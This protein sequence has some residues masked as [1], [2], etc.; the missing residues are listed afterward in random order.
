[1]AVVL[2]SSRRFRPFTRRRITTDNPYLLL[3]GGARVRGSNICP[4]PLPGIGDWH[5]LWEDWPWTSWIKFQVDLL[6]SVGGN[7]VRLMGTYKGVYDATINIA[8]VLDR[9][10]QLA[11]YTA[12][13]GMYLYPCVGGDFAGAY[14]YTPS[15]AF[16]ADEAAAVAERLREYDHIIGI[17]IVQERS[18]SWAAT[19]GEAA[20]SAVKAET[21]VPLTYSHVV[22]NSTDLAATTWRSQLDRMVDFFDI[23]I[24]SY[25]LGATD[26]A[27]QYWALGGTKPTL[28]GEFGRPMSDGSSARAGVYT[29]TKAGVN[30]TASIATG[31]VYLAGALSWAISD[32]DTVSSNQWGM[33]DAAGVARTNVTSIFSTFP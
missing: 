18:T 4:Q 2:R 1:M 22:T 11:E 33:F 32:Q 29:A 20:Y 16:V 5:N 23:H 30:A 28:I 10:D 17:D 31:T 21:D 14:G 8:T 27:N 19:N 25:D 12:S 6:Q 3:P 9:W 26:L 15:N 13:I 24:N 7:T